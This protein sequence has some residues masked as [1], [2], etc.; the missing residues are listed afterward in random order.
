MRSKSVQADS[1][2]RLGL[3]R[4]SNDGS[5]DSLDG[6][7]VDFKSS[8]KSRKEKKSVTLLK[9]SDSNSNSLFKQK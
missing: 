5:I 7:S 1:E 8:T 9:K 2:E 4:I 3:R 6:V